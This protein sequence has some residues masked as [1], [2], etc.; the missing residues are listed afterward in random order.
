M[1]R[2]SVSAFNLMVRRARYYL[3]FVR[4]QLGALHDI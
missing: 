1:A 3:G 2:Y 4:D